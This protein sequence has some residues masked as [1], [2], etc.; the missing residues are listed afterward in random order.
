MMWG[1]YRGS[2]HWGVML[3][4]MVLSALAWGTVIWLV[5]RLLRSWAFHSDFIR[6]DTREDAMEILRRRLASGEISRD[7]FHSLKEVH[8]TTQRL[9]ECRV[10]RHVTL[11]QAGRLTSF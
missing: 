1:W 11:G 10:W 3:V 5:F 8:R 9:E 2:G 7:E 6:Q 4:G